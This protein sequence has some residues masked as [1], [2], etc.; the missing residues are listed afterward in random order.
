MS[1]H[2]DTELRSTS[3]V[4]S[5]KNSWKSESYL[6]NMDTGAEGRGRQWEAR[7][8]MGSNSMNHWEGLLLCRYQ[9]IREG[10]KRARAHVSGNLIWR[11]KEARVP[12]AGRLGASICEGVLEERA[13]YGTF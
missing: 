2:Q 6:G 11:G 12:G 1:S 13:A 8:K 10:E 9:G 4:A 3:P 5:V 7:K